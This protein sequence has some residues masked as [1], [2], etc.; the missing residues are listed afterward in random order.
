MSFGPSRTG[1]SCDRD[2]TQAPGQFQ[3]GPPA[4]VLWANFRVT[5]S[6]SPERFRGRRLAS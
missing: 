4:A 3:L 1:G 5:R 2:A 6:A